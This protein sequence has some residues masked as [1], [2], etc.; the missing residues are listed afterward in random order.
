M[1]RRGGVPNSRRYSRLKCDGLS[2]PTR[3]AT[4]AASRLSPSINRRAS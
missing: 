1:F 2:Y 3:D 4:P